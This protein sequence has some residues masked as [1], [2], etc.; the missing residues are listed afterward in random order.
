M[1]K[2]TLEG[3]VL[4][5]LETKPSIVQPGKAVQMLLHG[6][7][8]APHPKPYVRQQVEE[9]LHDLQRGHKVR[10]V[11]RG[12]VINEIHYKPQA[13]SAK[14]SKPSTPAQEAPMENTPQP[15]PEQKA[16]RLNIKDLP[17]HQQL[18]AALSVLQQY[19]DDKG[20]IKEQTMPG[21]LT[22]A[23]DIAPWKAHTLGRQL[24]QLGLRVMTRVGRGYDFLVEMNVT[25]VTPEMVL[26]LTEAPAQKAADE[27]TTPD[28]TELAATSDT[29]PPAESTEVT[30]T[31]TEK[32]VPVTEAEE[33]EA[34]ADED[35]QG[36]A[37]E[38]ITSL[39]QA[40]ESLNSRLAGSTETITSLTNQL[41]EAVNRNTQLERELRQLRDKATK[42]RPELAQ[43]LEELRSKS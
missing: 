36:V 14:P 21:M 7:K 8:E 26:Q 30:E 19:A 13:R 25:E 15:A 31:T 32:E 34:P 29:V 27:V 10:L 11:K 43:L 16:V 3:K 41:T 24:E 22:S 18:T 39:R 38:V 12:S 9:I 33:P 17:H 23:L 4:C 20:H 2:K 42:P 28:I 35:W 1:R 5:Y 40:N 37:L 6:I